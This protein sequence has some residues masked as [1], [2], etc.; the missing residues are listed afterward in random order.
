MWY[1]RPSVMLRAALGLL[2]LTLWLGA[3][4][5]AWAQI[6]AGWYVTPSFVIFEEFDD[7][8]FVT[9]TDKQSDFITRFIPGLEIGYRTE[10]LTVSLGGS[11][12]S[13]IYARNTELSE[14]AVR[15]RAAL[16]VKYLPYRLLTLGLDVTYLDTQTPSELV[17]ATGLQLARQHATEL[18]AN[19]YAVYQLTAVDTLRGDYSFIRGTIEDGLDNYVHRVRLGYSRLF[20]AR[21]TGFAA[22]R[23]GVYETQDSPTA[24]SNTL[25]VGW[26]HQFTP[27]TFLTLEG[28]P[29]LVDNKPVEDGWRVRPDAH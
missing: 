7:N 3:P 17:P 21:D 18:V 2:M 25:A 12:D 9:A 29:R 27:T 6:P 23:L 5:P 10:P 26:V 24:Y 11:F 14:A 19:P 28:G 20:G 8:V 22:Y 16:R 1:K 4:P 13:E 15:W